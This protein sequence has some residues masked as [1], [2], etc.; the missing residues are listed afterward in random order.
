MGLI[1][2]LLAAGLGGVAFWL[3]FGRLGSCLF[4]LRQGV[5]TR[6]IRGLTE[7]G[8]SARLELRWD[9]SAIKWG[10]CRGGPG[11]DAFGYLFKSS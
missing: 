11:R 4:Q 8:L 2:A 3:T 1:L 7:S 10:E 6:K 5:E 9:R